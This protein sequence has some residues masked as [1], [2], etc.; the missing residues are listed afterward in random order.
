VAGSA[1]SQP[2]NSVRSLNW[3]QR[4]RGF[5]GSAVWG[6]S[7]MTAVLRKGGCARKSAAHLALEEVSDEVPKSPDQSRDRF[8]GDDSRQVRRYAGHG[9]QLADVEQGLQDRGD[10][11]RNGNGVAVG[12]SAVAGR[13]ADSHAMFRPPPYSISGASV[14][15]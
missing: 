5:T 11:V 7:A 9:A 15:Q 1:R 10:E 3:N 13:L 14:P 8:R 12:F 4:R 6:V 2:I